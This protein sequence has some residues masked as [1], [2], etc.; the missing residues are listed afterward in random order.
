MNSTLVIGYGNTLR[1][2]DA[3][4]VRAA[5]FIARRAAGVECLC[6]HQL[7]PE[8]AENLSRA[9]TV[10]FLDAHAGITELTVRTLAAEAVPRMHT[11]I[12]SPEILLA[13][14]SDLYGRVPCRAFAIGIPA[15]QFDFTEELSP[16][17]QQAVLTAVEKALECIN[18]NKISL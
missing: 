10:V 17:T 11:H 15:M 1:G 3:A 4:G 16:E 13:L 9:D 7:T 6:I 5:E 12:V 2:D 18:Q 8:L 14:C